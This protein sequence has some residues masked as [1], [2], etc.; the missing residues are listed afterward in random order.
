MDNDAKQ[1]LIGLT[2]IIVANV[3]C[4]VIMIE[5]YSMRFYMDKPKPTPRPRITTHGY[6]RDGG[7]RYEFTGP[8]YHV[9]NEQKDK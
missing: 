3:M 7:Q 1:G 4:W 5:G 8:C 6:N 9:T 2:A